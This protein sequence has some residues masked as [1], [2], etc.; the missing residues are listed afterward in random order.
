MKKT[1]LT[2]T[3]IVAFAGAASA[4]VSLSGY[5]EIGILQSDYSALTNGSAAGQLVG[6]GDMR[7]HHDIDVKFSLSGETD[8][9]L[10]FGATI[11]LDEVSNGISN[12]AN[13]SS[14]F[15]SGGF[16]TV[17]LGDTDGALDWAMQEVGIGSAIA[18]DH[19]THAGFNFNSGHDGVYD[20]QVLRY[21]NT[22]GDFGVALSAELDDSSVGDTAWGL[23]VKYNA[24]LGGVDLGLGLGYQ[25]DNVNDIW[26]LSVDAKFG[27][28]FRAILNYSDLDGKVV[29]G[30]AMD[31]HYGIGLGYTSGA[32][33]VSAN[34]GKYGAV[35]A[36]ADHTGYGLAVNYDLGGGA[37]VMAGYGHGEW[38]AA[39]AATVTDATSAPVALG[40]TDQDTFSIGLGLS[41]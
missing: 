17:T 6:D 8:N 14:V 16:G 5:A 33:T 22:F 9:G 29:G 1:L 27:G 15:I 2:T 41:F 36:N 35:A 3:A 7:F 25:S 23:G 30:D 38:D 26:G 34:Y 18:D 12:H 20:G 10:T 39:S 37:V 11:D 24:A 13:P 4:E 32:L 21:D 31:N 28:G 19:T 40:G